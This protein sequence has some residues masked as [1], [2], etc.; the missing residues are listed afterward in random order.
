MSRPPNDRQRE[1][2]ANERTFLAWLRTAVALIGFGFAIA[3]FGLFLRQLKVALTHQATPIDSVFNSES[4]GLCLVLLG[5]VLIALAAW[6]Y[7]QVLWQIERGDYRPSR[8]IIWVI[9]GIMVLLGL[10]SIPL[11][12]TQKQEPTLPLP[13]PRKP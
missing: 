11:L 1:H 9:T 8:L 2:Q 5:V 7:E 12:L 13:T 3:R 6:R 4:L 10:L